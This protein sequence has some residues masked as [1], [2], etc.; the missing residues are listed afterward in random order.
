MNRRCLL[1]V[2]CLS[3]VFP[4]VGKRV[5][6]DELM[7]PN[8]AARMGLEEAWQR[9]LRVPAGAPSIVHQE[10]ILHTDAPKEY[11]EI[12]GKAEEGKQAPVLFRLDVNTPGTTGAAIG[13]AEAERLA[14][15]EVRRLKRHGGD[16][17]IT[18]RTVPRINLYTA[19]NN[20]TIECRDAETGSPLWMT[21]VGDAR[22]GYGKMG[23]DNKFLTITNGANLIKIDATNGEPIS[24]DRTFSVPLYGAIHAGG[25]SILPTIRNGIEGYSL[26]ETDDVPFMEI[27][28]GLALKPPTKSPSSAKVA[29]GTDRSFVYVM[30]T[31]G[32]PSVLFRL[33]TDGIVSA[34]IAAASGDRFFFGSESGQVY[35]VKATRN[36]RVLWSQPY[37]EPFYKNPMLIDGV[38]LMPSEYGNLFALDEASGI[39]VWNA[40]APNVDQVVGG[41]DGKVFVRF[42][43]GG[44]GAIDLKTGK[45]LDVDR[46]LVPGRLL[47]NRT[48]NRL[49]LVNSTGTVQCLRPIGAE[50]P[51]LQ[52]SFEEFTESEEQK[53]MKT[54]KTKPD[55][56]NPFKMDDPFGAGAD[57][58]GGGANPDDPFG[59]PGPPADDPFGAPAGG[60]NN[61]FGGSPF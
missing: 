49:Y 55:D 7:S 10:I 32:D 59:T 54:E 33:N 58:F 28:S 34:Q 1:F 5:C 13:K 21:Q 52:K 15:R 44:F 30:E 24:N 53:P 19:A 37:G 43:S 14:R 23:I 12:L 6:A 39:S 11:V 9:Q 4:L 3:T 35:G 57:A 36:G 27:V 22:L 48:T 51:S 56:D 45:L 17:K 42:I 25:Y 26:T 60:G 18:S 8:S 38:L 16:P 40:P 2:A 31:S 29:W 46:Q 61:P 41:F 47:V 20:G 50:L